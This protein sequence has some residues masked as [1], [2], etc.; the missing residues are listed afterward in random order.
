[1][2]SGA[3]PIVL[4]PFPRDAASMTEIQIAPWLELRE[5]ILS[6]RQSGVVVVDSAAILGSM[7]DLG[8]LDGTYLPEFT[9][10]GVHPNNAGHAAVADALMVE[11]SALASITKP[12]P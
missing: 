3:V 8:Q 6:M 2:V 4:T 9:S 5:N 10:D 11:L 7:D 12:E 1:M